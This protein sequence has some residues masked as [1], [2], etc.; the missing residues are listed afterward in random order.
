MPMSVA[1]F[2]QLK[3][4]LTLATSENDHEALASWR[5]ATKLVAKHGYTWEMVLSRTVT[6]I[7]E[8]VPVVAGDAP[9][10]MD[11][12]FDLALRGADGS[13]RETLLSIKAQYDARGFLSPRQREVVEA[14]AERRVDRRSDGRVR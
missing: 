14:A 12:M 5:A 8:V 2:G 11:N 4:L 10:D 3:K 13:F 6:V 7:Q 9:D 1:E